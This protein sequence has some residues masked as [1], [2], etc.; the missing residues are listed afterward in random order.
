[1]RKCTLEGG[2]HVVS[3]LLRGRRLGFIP[4]ALAAIWNLPKDVVVV[5][6]PPVISNVPLVRRL[7]RMDRRYCPVERQCQT[8]TI[9]AP[10][11]I[12][13]RINSWRSVC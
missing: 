11:G 13:S 10:R 7:I 5:S 6:A 4:R 3:T 2:L 8:E 12:V 1:M 9:S